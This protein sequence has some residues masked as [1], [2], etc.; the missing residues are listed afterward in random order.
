MASPAA[1][2]TTAVAK[3][4]SY[5]ASTMPG[6]R[7]SPRAATVAGPDPETAPQKAA[8]RTVATASPPGMS[9][10]S[11]L[12]RA[13]RRSAIPTF[14]IMTPAMTKKGIASRGNLAMPEK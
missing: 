4:L 8:T 12:I 9:P 5:P 10:T 6:I 1:T 11:C 13:I 3:G 14:S 2:D 7:I